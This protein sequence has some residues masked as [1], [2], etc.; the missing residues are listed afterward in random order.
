MLGR[1]RLGG[2]G[3]DTE[4]RPEASDTEMGTAG[5]EDGQ[6]SERG[7]QCR[8]AAPRNRREPKEWSLC[9]MRLRGH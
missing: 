4:L 9:L 8:K 6:D 2:T 7:S 3:R 5:G 1:H